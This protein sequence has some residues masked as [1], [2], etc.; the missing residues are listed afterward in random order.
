MGKGGCQQ[1]KLEQHLR[2][3]WTCSGVWVRHVEPLTD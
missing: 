2:P 3:V 1:L